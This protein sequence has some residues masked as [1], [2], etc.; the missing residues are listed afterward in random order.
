MTLVAPG[1]TG[2]CLNARAAAATA[3]ARFVPTGVGLRIAAEMRA[4][5]SDCG[6]PLTTAEV[7]A[8]IVAEPPEWLKLHA[9][10]ART[11]RSAYRHHPSHT[12]ETGDRRRRFHPPH[13][14]LVGTPGDRSSAALGLAAR[15]CTPGFST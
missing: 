14:A 4:A 15:P 9:P 6:L 12:R 3:S 8:V 11:P 2:K 7:P 5:D 13:C 10:S 1:G